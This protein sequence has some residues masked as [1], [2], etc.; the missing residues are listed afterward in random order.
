MDVVLFGVVIGAFFTGVL[1][2]VL[3]SLMVVAFRWIIRNPFA[4]VI[5]IKRRHGVDLNML[6][7]NREIFASSRR[8]RARIGMVPAILMLIAGIG[9]I[10]GG[11]L[12]ED[13][14]SARRRN[15][16][17]Q[18]VMQRE[19]VR[20]AEA[21]VKESQERMRR[22]LFGPPASEQQQNAGNANGGHP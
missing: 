1:F 21:A 10:I 20:Q 13:P 17:I 11:L 5:F 6:I 2:V 4:D 12:A 8:L 22:A 16:E 15:E 9:L 14:A 19:N 3:G 7:T 18:Q